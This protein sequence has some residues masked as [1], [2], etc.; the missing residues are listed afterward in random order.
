MVREREKVGFSDLQE[1]ANDSV[2]YKN[3]GHKYKDPPSPDK[4]EIRDLKEQPS[5]K[6]IPYTYPYTE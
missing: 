2:D 5:T 1:I 3:D 6:R 4:K